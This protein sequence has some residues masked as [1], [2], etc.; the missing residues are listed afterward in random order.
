MHGLLPGLFFRFLR[1]LFSF[2][3]FS[4]G[5]RQRH[6]RAGH[7]ADEHADVFGLLLRLGAAG[8]LLGTIPVLIQQ[9]SRCRKAVQAGM[10]R[11][12]GGRSRMPLI[13]VAVP[14]PIPSSTASNPK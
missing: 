14:Y 10:E 2:R 9:R 7:K 3:G 13:T 5:M 6:Y 4:G 8:P 1:Y 12:Q 11:T